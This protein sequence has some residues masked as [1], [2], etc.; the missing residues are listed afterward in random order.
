MWSWNSTVWFLVKCLLHSRL[1][2]FKAEMT[3]RHLQRPE[4]GWDQEWRHGWLIVEELWWFVGAL[5]VVG[6][7]W[8]MLLRVVIGRRLD[9]WG[10]AS[11][12]GG[13]GLL[14]YIQLVGIR[15]VSIGVGVA[16]LV[17]NG[18]RTRILRQE[19]LLFV[20]YRHLPLKLIRLWL[21]IQQ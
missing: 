10:G 17:G 18:Y 5:V 6:W 15:I 13:R 11:C 4:V 1:A 9:E 21:D 7:A 8:S 2:I 20:I 12:G 14:L 16:T 3:A 19:S